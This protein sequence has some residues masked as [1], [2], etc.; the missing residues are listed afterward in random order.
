[1]NNLSAIPRTKS[2]MAGRRAGRKQ[3]IKRPYVRKAAVKQTTA[4][5]KRVLNRELETK[6]VATQVS[7]TGSVVKGFCNPAADAI[8][9]LCPVAFQGAATGAASNL[10][11]GDAI[12]PLRASIKGHIW[13][14]PLQE[15]QATSKILFVKM[16]ILTSKQIKS[17]QFQGNLDGGWL[18]NGTI[19]PVQWVSTASDLQSFYPVAKQN[20]NVLKTRTFKF[21]KN[22]GNCIADNTAGNS[23]N[24]NVDRKT[25]SYSWKPPTLKYADES[26]TLPTNHFPFMCLVAY[27][28]GLD[29]E[30]V[31]ELK[32]ALLYNFN[33]EMYYKDA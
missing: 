19:N 32:D 1:M 4:I 24:L 5:V 15:V 7:T 11:E 3:G 13:F 30:N 2:Y 18:E 12:T 17:Q 14:N 9:I 26:K 28:P 8:S 22:V 25:F 16:F 33:S 31:A 20:Y 10:R 6:Y 27:A 29:V 23:P 21:V